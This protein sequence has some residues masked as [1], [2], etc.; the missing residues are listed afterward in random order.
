MA[1]GIGQQLVN[2]HA[3]RLRGSRGDDIGA[4]LDRDPVILADIEMAKLAGDQIVHVHA[5]PFAG[6]QQ[7]LADRQRLQALGETA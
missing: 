4:A 1:A 5:T 2:G 6:G 3:E 7:V